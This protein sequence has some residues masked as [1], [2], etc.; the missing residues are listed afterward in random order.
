M[1]CSCAGGTDW[2]SRTLECPV[3]GMNS[4]RDCRDK[5]LY[6]QIQQKR[7]IA[8]GRHPVRR[9]LGRKVGPPEL[10]R[11][12]FC[13][14][15]LSG[16]RLPTPRGPF[17][18]RGWSDSVRLGL[19]H[20]WLTGKCCRSIADYRPR[21]LSP[22]KISSCVALRVIRRRWEERLGTHMAQDCQGG[23]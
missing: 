23:L 7:G 11:D 18:R 6:Y 21:R 17:A 1:Q 10:G 8:G 3:A 20:G 4:S 13:A 12:L 16:R 14:T 19:V 15:R 9:F 2:A 22:F 5:R